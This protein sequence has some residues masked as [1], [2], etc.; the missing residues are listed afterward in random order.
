MKKIT[1]LLLVLLISIGLVG[2]DSGKEEPTVANCSFN[3][4]ELTTYYVEFNYDK[5]GKVTDITLKFR[6][7]YQDFGTEEEIT[8]GAR[9]LS[10]A[11]EPMDGM[12]YTFEIIDGTILEDKL[13]IDLLV[14]DLEFLAE[15]SLFGL[16][17]RL[18]PEELSSKDLLLGK[19]TEDNSYVCE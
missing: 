16:K 11:F 13:V 3:M 6:R 15:P 17:T 12:I 7:D 2:C 14:A 10:E 18:T 9:T 19:L 1:A 4:D 5:D 8:N